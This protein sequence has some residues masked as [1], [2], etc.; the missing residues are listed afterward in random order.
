MN[1]SEKSKSLALAE[2]YFQSNQYSFAESILKIILKSEPNNSKANELLAYI[3]GNQGNSDLAYQ[4]L[5]L[6]CAQDDCSPEALYY[7]GSTQ[8]NLQ[9]LDNASE[10]LK[11]SI[12]KA[13]VYFEALHDL[14]TVYGLMGKTQEAL[15]CYR[16]CLKFNQNSHELHFNIARCLDELKQYQEALDHYDKA[17]QLK[18]DY[19]EAWSN[20]GITL[21]DL[22]R[23]QEALDSYDQALQLK[24]EYAEAWSNKGNALYQLRRFE[25][26]LVHHDRAIQ[27]KP[28][29]FDA[30]FNKSLVCLLLQDFNNGWDCYS[31]RWNRKESYT[32][33]HDQWKELESL[34]DL[35]DKKVLVWYEQG[36][37]DTIQFSRYIPRLIELGA[38]VTFEVQEPL[39]NLLSPQLDCHV[40]SELDTKSEFDY[41]V[42]L[43]TLAK[44]FKT[45]IENIPKPIPIK[46]SPQKIA[47]W[48]KLLQLSKEKL[49]IGIAISGN[50]NHQN[51]SNRSMSLQDLAP[52]FDFGKFFLI[53]KELKAVDSDIVNLNKNVI[54]L[55]HEINDFADTAAIIS[56]MD[57]IISVDTS[58]IHVAGSFNKKSYLALAWCPEWRWLLD[59]SDS[60]WYPSITILR[61]KSPH[62]WDSVVRELK[63]KLENKLL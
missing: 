7:L 10:S 53:Q 13:G 24:P 21:H 9:L 59:R 56:H 49:N 14:G 33:R 3:Y 62:S 30:Y 20:K 38:N 19:A 12:K 8:L 50:Q 23:Y 2:H 17:L 16:D 63:M 29:Y 47:Q 4:L 6:S 58:L 36:L 28:D 57:L 37:G 54:Y 44:L 45:T 46:P 42:P 31:Y 34:S 26:A 52:L 1:E 27:L 55:G 61:Q 15:L 18:P 40:V 11:R 22:R 48:Q 51:D 35:S 5:K 43:L 41:Q 60:P 39:F 25:E 32:Y